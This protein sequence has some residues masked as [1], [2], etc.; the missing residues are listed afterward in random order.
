MA[1]PARE[2]ILPASYPLFEGSTVLV[3]ED[4]GDSLDM[5]RQMLEALGIRVLAAE[6]GRQA[7]TLLEEEAPD[8]ILCDL[9]MPRVDGFTLVERLRSDPHRRAT[10]AIAVS[11]LGYDSDYQRT[12]AAGFDG[13]L[14]KPID[15]DTVIETLRR[16]LPPGGRRAS[17]RSDARAPGRKTGRARK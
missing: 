17:R 2:P 13:H 9:L 12:W 14:V 5:M 11:G 1:E 6:D 10:P 8:L 3:V 4:Q 16:Y 7:L 15:I